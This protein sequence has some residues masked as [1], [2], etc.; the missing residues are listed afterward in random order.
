[1]EL[2]IDINILAGGWEATGL[3]LDELV[4]SAI[5][6]AIAHAEHPDDIMGRD[7]EL[8]VVLTDDKT[9]QTLNA[10]YRGKDKPTNVLSF[11]TL[12]GDDPLPPEGPIHIGDI[13]LAFETLEREAAELQKPLSDHLTHLLVHGTLHLLGYD[14]ENDSDANVMESLEITVLEIFGIENPYSETRFMQ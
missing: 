8:S 12:D 14:H 3:P 1:M 9:V 7:I 5:A 4:N 13:V 11:A 2:S 6:A 10:E